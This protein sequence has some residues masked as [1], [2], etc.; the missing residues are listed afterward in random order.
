MQY[1]KLGN[2][3]L[4][5]SK[6][7]L[8]AM[9]FGDVNVGWL[10]K[11]VLNQADTTDMI[12]HSLDL[13]I[14]FFDCAN[15]YSLG[16]SEEY[17]G[18]A[19]KEQANRDNIVIAT[20]VFGRMYP[21]PNGQGLSRKHILSAC[22][23]SLRRLQTDYIDLYIIHRFDYDTPIEETM[24]ALDS[25][26]K[27]GKVRYIGASS[28]FAWQFLQMQHISEKNCFAKFVSMQNHYNLIYREEEREMMP[29]CDQLGIGVTPYSPLAAGRLSRKPSDVT[30][31]KATDETAGGK[32]DSTI[33]IDKPII[34]RVHQI[35]SNR[36]A[37]A[38]QVSLA[39]LLAKPAVSSPI[40]GTTKK[41]QLTDAVKAVQLSLTKDEIKYLEETYQPHD[42]VGAR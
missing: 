34:E 27:S 1:T 9:S 14:N 7:C 38:T 21:G 32:Y 3:G 23:D 8:G 39:W 29:M 18:A 37:T 42:V 2:T 6:L 15:I 35:A 16:T 33:D 22:D 25:L 5:I 41:D 31:R 24:S 26:V 11:W 13:G 30:N 28:M 40:I 17:V 10:H 19:L 12:K 20:K 36:G 4:D